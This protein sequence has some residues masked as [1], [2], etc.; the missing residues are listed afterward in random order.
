MRVLYIT[1]IEPSEKFGGGIA[2]LQ[3]LRSISKIAIIDYL[4]IQYDV[5]AFAKYGIRVDKSYILNKNTSKLKQITN[6]IIYGATSSF[7]D[8]WKEFTKRIDLNEYDSVY[9]DF[10]RQSFVAKWVWKKHKPLIIRAHNVEYDYFSSLYQNNRSFINYLHS[11]LAYSNEKKCIKYSTKILFL[12]EIDHARFQELYGDNNKFVRYPICVSHF[13][14]QETFNVKKPYILITGS[15]WFGPNADGTLWFLKKVWSR[16]RKNIGE[17]FD[18]VIAGAKPRDEII[19][20]ANRDEFI[21]LYDTPESIAPFYNSAYVYVAP[22]FYGA[23]MKVKV[24]EALS[25]GLPVIATKHALAGY[26]AVDKYTYSADTAEEF[27]EQ[28]KRAI[29]DDSDELREQIINSFDK[30]YSLEAS[31]K[32][33]QLL[34]QE[35]KEYNE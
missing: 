17:K 15:L 10:T 26:E 21:H 22:I 35:I 8:S 18:L 34:L 14:K 3:T 33:I 23:G 1:F 9:M 2:I 4:G 20:I 30:N 7:Y 25:C 11:K 27:I 13:D 5:D 32:I 16:L 6:S 31:D 28:I 12:T 19:E 29:H 24:A